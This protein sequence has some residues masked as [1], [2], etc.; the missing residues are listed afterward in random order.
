MKGIAGPA[1]YLLMVLGGAASYAAART[2]WRP[3][4]T[5]RG[6]MWEPWLLLVTGSTAACAAVVLL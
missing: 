1:L 3:A 2:L 4:S 6:P 5:R